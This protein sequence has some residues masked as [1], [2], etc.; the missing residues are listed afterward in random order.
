MLKV[1]KSSYNIFYLLIS[2]I[3]I[4]TPVRA[5]VLD[6]KLRLQVVS[7]QLVAT[8]EN[9]PFSDTVLGLPLVEWIP[10]VDG[11]ELRLWNVRGE[12]IVACASRDYSLRFSQELRH[13]KPGEII[14]EKFTSEDVKRTFC[15]KRGKYLSQAILHS[16]FSDN[17]APIVLSNPVLF[18]VN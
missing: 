9:N 16:D 11:V 1:G 14:E 18:I 15:L 7:D 5:D 2:V 12:V 8:I 10:G 3:F 13:L 4:T 6:I 17:S